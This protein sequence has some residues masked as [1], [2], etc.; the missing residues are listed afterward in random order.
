MPS[1]TDLARVASLIADPSRAAMLDALLDG[2]SHTVGE[3]ARA[4]QVSMSTASEHV[5]RLVDGGLV[6]MIQDGRRHIVRLRSDSVG[7]ALEQ[8]AALTTDS[9]APPATTIMARLQ[10][11][12]TCYDH[13]A[14]RLGV[15]VAE[16][17]VERGALVRHEDAFE[18]TQPG[19]VWLASIGIDVD[20][21]RAGQRVLARSCND[22]TERR[23][24]I[25]GRLGAALARRALELGWVV[26]ITGTRALLVTPAGRAFLDGELGISVGIGPVRGH[27]VRATSTPVGDDGT[28]LVSSRFREGPRVPT[29]ATS[30]LREAPRAAAGPA[31]WRSR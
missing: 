16:V 26:R 12:R 25:A 30:T 24:H 5:R 18:V 21:L 15:S 7:R 9:A 19:R 31:G 23:P 1:T 11:A 20:A 8:L 6:T 4:A 10:T 2:T 17:L 29:A 13:L 22:W 27:H 28:S 3:L 14:G